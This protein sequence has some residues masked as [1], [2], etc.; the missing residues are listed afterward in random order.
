MTT[1][2]HPGAAISNRAAHAPSILIVDD[3]NSV[4]TLMARWLEAGGFR[5]TTA[6]SAEEALGRLHESPPAVALCDIRMP[7]HDGVWL[8]ERIRQEYPETAVIMATGVQDV[9]PAVQALRQGVIDYLTKPFGRDRLRE[10]VTRGLEWHEAAW[11][12]RRWRESLEEEMSIRR[13][14]LSDAIA[15]LRVDSDDMVD[16]MFAMLTLGDREM[17]EHGYRVS[18]LAVSVA[19]ILGLPAEA[20]TTIEHGALLHDIGKLAVPEAVLR[21]PAP[22]TVEETLLVRRHPAIASDLVASVPFL[23]AT[24][25]IVREAHERMDG[26]GYPQGIHAAEVSIGARIV[27]VA[28]AYD[29]M[30]RPRVFRDAM[31]PPEALLELERCSGTQFD[32]LVV[33]AFGRVIR[34]A[35]C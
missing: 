21:K 30:T 23:H 2:K 25:P 3:E 18:A 11:D 9:G 31:T 6:G 35:D 4:R 5:V 24:V 27:S 29:T 32:P 7:G 17:Y 33:E 34:I 10:A 13:A 26:L 20:L 1:R 12:A 16:S 22:L 8:A 14:R 15:G 28:D 19:R